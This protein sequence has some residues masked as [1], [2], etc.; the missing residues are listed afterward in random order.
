MRHNMI[1]AAFL[2]N[3]AHKLIITITK[4]DKA[5]ISDTVTTSYTT[6]SSI[7]S[8]GQPPLN[9]TASIQK[10]DVVFQ[11]SNAV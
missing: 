9:I 4:Y 7:L 1:F 8:L 5:K 11:Q 6:N 3:L 2:Q 10:H